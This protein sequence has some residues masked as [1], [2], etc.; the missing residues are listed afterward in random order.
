MKIL[1]LFPILFLLS[2][3]DSHSISEQLE[4][5]VNYLASDKLEGRYP[6]TEGDSLSQMYI[7]NIFKENGLESLNSKSEYFQDFPFLCRINAS[8]TNS[9]S[10]K[11]SDSLYQLK[12]TKDFVVF[13]QSGSDK[14]SGK[15]VFIGYG[16]NEKINEYDDYH[17]IDLS[18]KV[19]ICYMVPPKGIE[20][21]LRKMSFKLNTTEKAKLL[22]SLGCKAIIFVL[23][24]SY[25]KHDSIIPLN[26]KRRFSQ[27]SV[28]EQIPMIRLSY[29]AY[30][31]L[32]KTANID[33]DKINKSLLT[34]KS[35][36]SFELPEI[37]ISIDIKV[38]YE[39]SRATNIVGFLKGKDTTQSII[40][41]AHYDHLGIKNY[42][43][44]LDSIYNGADDNASGISVL[45]EMSK[46]CSTDSLYDCN[47]CFVAFGAEESGLVGSR[48]FINNLPSKTGK[49]KCMINYDMVGR[50]RGDTLHVNHTKS[51][52]EWTSFLSTNQDY[53]FNLY[54]DE[55]VGAT[56]SYSFIRKG[57][58]SLWFFTG[59]HSNYHKPSDEYGTLNYVGMERILLF[60]KELISQVSKSSNELSFVEFRL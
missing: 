4:K 13:S 24:E 42:R 30:K 57:I 8:N 21:N 34:S 50:M 48:Y 22:K 49:I 43:S 38:N 44:M 19:A 39:F 59:Y 60:S 47:I 20:K 29:S 58:P 11:I 7:E 33:I 31:N 27:K 41:G 25:K 40:I 15:L 6:T 45:L 17:R 55:Q 10:I 36:L 32:M 2:C 28:Q 46:L 14:I 35:S 5:H 18:D 52:K 54:F 12:H 26:E 1:F 37:S 53:N 3:Q 16:I 23:P 51:A 56:D 9:I